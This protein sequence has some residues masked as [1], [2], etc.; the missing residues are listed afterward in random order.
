MDILYIQRKVNGKIVSPRKEIAEQTRIRSN[1]ESSFYTQLRKTFINIGD[2]VADEVE[3]GQLNPLY[4]ERIEPVIGDL[5]IA[6]YRKVMQIF[7]ERSLSL[8]TNLKRRQRTFEEYVQNYI[9]EVGGMKITAI[10]NT[11]RNQIMKIIKKGSEDGDNARKIARDI[12]L[13][14]NSPISRQRASL[15]A[16]TETHQ[17]SVYANHQVSIDQEI[18]EMQK[19]WISTNDDRTRLHHRQLNGITVNM[20]EDFVFNVGLAEYRMS[21]PADPRGGAINNINCRC[22]LAY[23]V[24]EDSIVEP[25]YSE[26]KPVPVAPVKVSEVDIRGIVKV[27]FR[28]KD[29]SEQYNDY[30]KSGL[31][32]LQAIVVSKVRL[33]TVIAIDGKAGYHS[34]S[35]TRSTVVAR[36]DETDGN[37][38]LHH[39]Y[40]HHIDYSTSTAGT[41]YWS[42]TNNQFRSAFEQDKKLN[43][44]DVDLNTGQFKLGKENVI[45]KLEQIK[46]QLFETIE[47]QETIKRGTF[48]G[49]K[50][51]RRKLKAKI[52]GAQGI[53][54]IYD[55]MTKGV[56]Y[57]DVNS[58]G[59]GGSYYRRERSMDLIETF[60]NMFEVYN[61][62]GGW[63]YISKNFPNTARV[64]EQRLKELANI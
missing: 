41:E 1:L 32:A 18:P 63:A 25:N 43:Q 9:R 45:Q 42:K 19:R 58:W 23:I 16:R 22:V 37:K 35:G 44:L 26:P 8:F 51:P 13:F 20:S 47:Y 55:A 14:S 6:H 56:M 40:G 28:G 27:K 57:D 33:P 62:K 29:L 3:Q 10:S 50:R 7:T 48:K 60:A 52:K 49:F 36:I 5:L 2:K 21:H 38:T 34:Y 17:A 12:Q 15:I 30:F 39:E 64:F 53:S 54:D 61:E 31:T 24:P 11:S 59:H 46:D 4:L